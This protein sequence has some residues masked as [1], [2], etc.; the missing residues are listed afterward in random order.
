MR[1]VVVGGGV[2]GSTLLGGFV[3]NGYDDVSVVEKFDERAQA[4]AELGFRIV[5]T[6]SD[7]DVIVLA[8]KPQDMVATVQDLDVKPG[9]LV[10]SIAAGI[11]T[12]TLESLLDGVS[13]VRAM[14]NTPSQLGLGMTAISAGTHCTDEDLAVAEA[15][16]ATVGV[17]VRVPEA[18]QD[19]VTA[20]SGS[21]PAYV[22]YLAE[23]MRDGAIALGLAPDVASTLVQQTLLG[24]ATL[25]AESEVDATELRR[26]VTSPG[27]TT[28]AAIEVFDARSVKDVVAAAMAAAAAR[29]KE[30]SGGNT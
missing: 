10:I 6:T 8:V 21:G 15:L 28:Q 29:G 12:T 9:A 27:G 17:V 2:M 30:L 20:T 23:A 1:I 7:A 18:Q 24:A 3:R 26:R 4:L 22:F 11:S 25:L 16:L 5:D 13:V 14:P 19:A